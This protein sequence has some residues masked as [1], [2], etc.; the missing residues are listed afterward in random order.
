[1]RIIFIIYLD[2]YFHYQPEK[3]F[4]DD[5]HDKYKVDSI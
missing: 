4:V 1:M 5:I 3:E 2:L